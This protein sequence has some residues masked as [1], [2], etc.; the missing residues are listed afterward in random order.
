LRPGDSAALLE[1][2]TWQRDHGANRLSDPTMTAWWAVAA[3][4]LQPANAARILHAAITRFQVNFEEKERST[5]AVALW[6]LVGEPELSFLLDWFFNEKPERGAF[7]NCLASF[8]DAVTSGRDGKQIIARIILDGRLK[9]LDWQSLE[10]LVRSVNGWMRAPVVTREE[11][12][13]A[14]HPLGQG[15]FHWSQA[16]AERLYPRETAELRR[17]LEEWRRRLI[18]SVPVWLPSR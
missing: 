7:P 16:E 12:E 4:R 14:W 18:T 5:I 10:R 13:N 3:A 2:E 11:M 17:Q 6:Q 8:I 9:N 1:C 15:H